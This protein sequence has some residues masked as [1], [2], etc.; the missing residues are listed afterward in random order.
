M[1]APSYTEDLTDFN[2]AESITGW[3]ELNSG[4][5][6]GQGGDAVDGDY[7]FIQGTY[8]NTQ[9]CTKDATNGSAAYD[10]GSGTGGHG[11]DGAYLVWQVYGVN[12][13]LGTYAQGGLG[14]AVGS[15]VDDFDVWYTGGI[16]IAPYPY[17]GW[18]CNAANTTVSADATVGSA[19]AT[20][21]V[22]GGTVY[23]A[24]GSGKGYPHG[25]DAIR[26]GRCSSIFEYGETADYCT[27]DGFATEDEYNDGT[28]GYHRWG[29]ITNTY[30]GYLWQG[31][32]TLGTATNA[33]DFRDS[34]V[35][36]FVK[37]CPKVTTNFNTIEVNNAGSRID[38]TNFQ[39]ICLTPTTNA[40]VGRWVTNADA[41][42]NLNTCA[43]T[44]M[45]EFDFGGTTVALSCTWNRCAQIDPNAGDLS[46]SDILES[47]VTGGGSTGGG[48]LHWND[49]G[50]P[51][52]KLNDMVISKGAGSHH[53]IEFGTTAPTTINL[54][55]MTFTD[56][57]ATDQQTTSVLYFPD[58]GS[59]TTWTI[60]HSGTTGTVS[61]YKARPG[62]TVNISGSVPV[63]IT[64]YDKYDGLIESGVQ[65]AVYLT[66]GRT[67]VMN[68][69]TDG[70]GVA[71]DSH[72]GATPAE[73]E[74]RCRKA[75][76]GADKFKNYS[77]IQTI[78]SGGLTLS[79][80]L[81]RDNNN[82]A[83]T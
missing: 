55:N 46:F 61:Y 7:P 32:M 31:K 38:M 69:D 8:A 4:G 6:D 76:S 79:V 48:A 2:L 56:F 73:A 21:Q 26:Y 64:V 62:D 47:S 66:T 57:S 33:V 58:K 81:E 17:G 3:D 53:A 15:S 40:S 50:D 30:G 70:T 54:T 24:T 5:Y 72:T 18:V 22:I 65:T 10:N 23:V 80:T 34:N 19:T 29:L 44:D 42:I 20:E 13:N 83:I 16:D 41:D 43:F 59:D 45:G 9:I 67:E 52:T 49:S 35:N 11:T 74:V 36:I 71:S 75:S 28:N 37:W 51:D 39:F 63:S 14:I 77:S 25:V 27:V 68:E 12:S 78:G 60:S 1:T 82:N